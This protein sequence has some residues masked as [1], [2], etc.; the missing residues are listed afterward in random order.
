MKPAGGLVDV[1]PQTYHRLG[2]TMLNAMGATSAGFGEE[3]SSG[4]LQ[5]VTLA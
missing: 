1:G 2:C 3:P 4:V 5:G